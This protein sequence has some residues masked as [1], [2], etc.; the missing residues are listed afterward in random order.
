MKGELNTKGTS[1]EA[2]QAKIDAL[3]REKGN[4]MAQ[5]R[6]ANEF[7]EILKDKN[8]LCMVEIRGTRLEAVKHLRMNEKLRT[9][10]TKARSEYR[11]FKFE[12]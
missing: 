10:V 9:E 2:V 11:D 6:E 8:E 1:E 3:Q 7:T 4:Y 5:I 12:A